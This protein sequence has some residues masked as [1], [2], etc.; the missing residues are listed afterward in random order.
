MHR[1]RTNFPLTKNGT[2][3]MPSL[4]E[5]ATARRAEIEAR[6]SELDEFLERAED[7]L[8]DAR[9]TAAERDH[10]AGGLSNVLIFPRGLR[11]AATA[12][13]TGA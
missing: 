10:R 5:I 2:R 11:Q 13:G 12:D 7:L 4:L 6:I 8:A 1:S 3:R 9:S